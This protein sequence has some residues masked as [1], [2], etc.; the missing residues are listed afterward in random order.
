MKVTAKSR[1][2]RGSMLAEMGT[3]IP[4]FMTMAAL[5]LDAIFGLMAH[6]VLDETSV[7]AARAAAFSR[8]MEEAQLRAATIARAHSRPSILPEV[9]VLQFNNSGK[10]Q[11]NPYLVLE[12]KVKYKMPFVVNCF[13]QSITPSNMEMHRIYAYPILPMKVPDDTSSGPDGNSE[14]NDDL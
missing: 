3:T 4:M 1:N 7:D 10:D 13:S 2:S 12:T 11:A 14:F 8:T 9:N 6:F 5:A